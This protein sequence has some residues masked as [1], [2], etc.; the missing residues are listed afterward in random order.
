MDFEVENQEKS[1]MRGFKKPS[2]F[3]HRFLMDLGRFWG[4]FWEDF[5][6]PGASK[7][8]G[9]LGPIGIFIKIAIF[10]EFGEGFGRLWGCFWEGLGR[11]WAG[12]WEGFGRVWELL[13]RF[14]VLRLFW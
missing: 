14:G 7:N 11:I 12:F 2:I 1:I 4:G 9:K 5:G 3:R 10:N 6:S 8:Q 13:G